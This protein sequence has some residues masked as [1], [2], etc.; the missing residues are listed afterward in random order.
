MG[1]TVL[2]PAR[3]CPNLMKMTVPFNP[4]KKHGPTGYMMARL[5]RTEPKTTWLDFA[6]R[7]KP[8][9]EEASQVLQRAMS[10]EPAE[11]L[12]IAARLCGAA[13]GTGI[14]DFDTTIGAI[15]SQLEG[16]EIPGATSGFAAGRELIK[17]F[18][19]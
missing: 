8:T 17:K 10:L 19:N 16:H 9:N 7:K 1:G 2:D 4:S 12:E 6:E 3:G 15:W 14:A 11:R 13:R 5:M 18:A